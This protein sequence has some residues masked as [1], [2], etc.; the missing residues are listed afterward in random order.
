MTQEHIRGV[1]AARIA[2]PPS[3]PGWQRRSLEDRLTIR[4][5]AGL[6]LVTRATARLSP[7][8]RPRQVLLARRIVQT[9]AAVNRR[10]FDVILAGFD[11]AIEYRPSIELMPPD[12][13][14]VSHGH[15]GFRQLWRYWMDAFPDLRWDPEEILDLGDRILV[16]ARQSGRG[17]GSGVAVSVSVYQLF[18]V[19]GGLV[20]RQEDFLERSQALHAAGLPG[21]TVERPEVP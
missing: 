16:T 21:E 7:R 2:L 1:N 17:S 14:A 18:T 5:P 4:F 15:D 13:G 12:L 8:S 20:T 10:D 6:R 9:Y 3:T 19:R 11:P